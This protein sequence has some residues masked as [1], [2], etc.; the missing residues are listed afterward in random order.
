MYNLAGCIA[1]HAALTPTSSE[2]LVHLFNM[3]I[4]TGL[5]KVEG[6]M[7]G[8]TI[9]KNGSIYQE[10]QWNAPTLSYNAMPRYFIRYADSKGGLFDNNPKRSSK[11]KTTLQ[12]TFNTSNITY[13][14]VV[15]VRPTGKQKRGDYSDPVS[16]TYTSKFVCRPFELRYRAC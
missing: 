2:A 9:V 8:N 1:R 7:F 14:V 5:P 3:L 16:I 6:V 10:V 12:L 15:A 13:Y 11:S 4:L